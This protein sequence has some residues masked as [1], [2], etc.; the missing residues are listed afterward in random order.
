MHNINRYIELSHHVCWY[1]FIFIIPACLVHYPTQNE[2]S[3]SISAL[4]SCVNFSKD[5]DLLPRV[6]GA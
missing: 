2:S 4:S 6:Y 3:V 1:C 5:Q